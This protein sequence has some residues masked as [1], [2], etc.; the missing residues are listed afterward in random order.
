MTDRHKIFL[1]SR[2]Q[3]RIDRTNKSQNNRL[4]V[5]KEWEIISANSDLSY[6]RNGSIKDYVKLARL[7]IYSDIYVKSKKWLDLKFFS[8]TRPCWFKS[9]WLSSSPSY[10]QYSK[11]WY[12][13][14]T[15]IS[16][17]WSML[18]NS[19]LE[20][21]LFLCIFFSFFLLLV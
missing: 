14:F 15:A 20:L 19:K 17:M 18:F 4:N 9:D 1:L 11:L 8:T 5:S 10:V 16:R 6:E 13:P 12:R 21:N 7:C 3:I 2:S